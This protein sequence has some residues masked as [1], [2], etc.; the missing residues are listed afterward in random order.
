MIMIERAS[1]R[2]EIHIK[3]QKAQVLNNNEYKNE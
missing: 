3:I 1:N 2:L